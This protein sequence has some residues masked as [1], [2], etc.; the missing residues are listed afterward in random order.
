MAAGSTAIRAGRSFVEMYLDDKKLRA[1]LASVQAQ[2]KSAGARLAVMGAAAAIGVAGIVS[3]LTALTSAEMNSID[4]T[5]KLSDSLGI[6]TEEFVRLRYAADL[7]GV[8]NEAF[9]KTI[10]KMVV[11]LGEAATGTG[12]TAEAL[13]QLGLDAQAMA[14]MSPD[15]AF[16]TISDSLAGVTNA[17]ERA[18][19]AYS[20]F[21][22]QGVAMLPLLSQGRKGIEATGAE[23]D[24]LALTFSRVDAA[25][26]EAANDAMTRVGKVAQGI[27]T[28]LAVEVAPFV[29]AIATKLFEIATAG[30]GL[31]PKVRGGF[32]LV[33]GGAAMLLDWLELGKAGFYS[34][35]YVATKQAQLM[36]MAFD[37]VA[38]AVLKVKDYVTGTKTD[39]VGFADEIGAAADDL[40]AKV[41]TSMENFG[42]GANS[43]A[44]AAMMDDIRNKANAAA[45][46][47]ADGA[48]KNKGAA[49][50]LEVLA[51]KLDAAAKASKEAEDKVSALRKEV[52]QFGMTD[53]EKFIADLSR[54][55]KGMEAQIE[56]AQE[57]LKKR[58]EL[59]AAVEAEKAAA[60]A[61]AQLQIQFDNAEATLKDLQFQ[62]DLTGMD[63]AQ[64]KLAELQRDLEE[65]AKAGASPEQVEQFR[66]LRES[67]ALAENKV[68]D[69]QVSASGTFNA[70]ALQG[71]SNVS[72]QAAD[73][74][75]KATEETAKQVKNLNKKADTGGLVFG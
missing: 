40:A 51:D 19:L 52:E 14:S 71:L 9:D 73:R 59:K 48:E 39:F 22:K 7:A 23:A 8:G 36:A 69:V 45:Q 56:A 20:I 64:K 30:E 61:Q 41:G 63:E 3:G 17:T 27:G 65:F 28:V 31:G 29:E 72:D 58:A 26:V 2:M 25:K 50:S 70:A 18:S 13:A 37:T 35:A 24:K 33:V 21:G 5:S 42:K 46:A 60:E 62:L 43:Q 34:L 75:A 12:A 47:V 57:L 4:A 15:E 44:A 1:G 54:G 38:R 10:Q 74:T 6:Q 55:Q 68:Q 53:D 67:L 49:A 16:K 32:E 66:K 11:N